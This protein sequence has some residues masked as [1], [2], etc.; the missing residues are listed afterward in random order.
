MQLYVDELRFRSPLTPET[1]IFVRADYQGKVISTDLSTLT[2]ESLLEWLKSRGG[3]NPWAEDT[4]GVILG[5]G[6]LHK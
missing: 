3:N 5:Y 4:V 1:G 2:K 6:R